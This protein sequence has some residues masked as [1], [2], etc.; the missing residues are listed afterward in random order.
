MNDLKPNSHR[1]KEEQAAEE[2]QK[3]TQKIIKGT[4][5][6]RKKSELAKLGDVFI[7]EDVSIL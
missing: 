5:K 1:F 3:K 2:R 7:S 4:A 6:T